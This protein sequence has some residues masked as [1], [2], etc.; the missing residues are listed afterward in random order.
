MAD[1]IQ[2]I[3]TYCPK[4]ELQKRANLQMVLDY[5][6]GS[7]NLVPSVAKQSIFELQRAIIHF[8]RMG[9][10]VK[11]DGLGTWI[12][13]MKLDGSLQIGI[14]PD[15]EFKNNLNAGHFHGEVINKDMIGES[16]ENLIE[17]WNRE[18]P[19][20]PVEKKKTKKKIPG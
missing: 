12:P 17:R 10:T 18:H 7:T 5:I 6:S 19:D 11:I 9:K 13:S 20:D 15:D 3:N 16:P 2:A 1:R 8:A 14:R 4:I